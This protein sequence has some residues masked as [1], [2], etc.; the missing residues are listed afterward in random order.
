MSILTKIKRFVQKNAKI[1][2]ATTAVAVAAGAGFAALG[3][4][5]ADP[6]STRNCDGN[7]MVY[8]GAESVSE[9][10]TKYNKGDSHNKVYTTQDMYHAGFGISPSDINAMSSDTTVGYVTKSGDVYSGNTLVATNALTGGRENIAGSTPEKYGATA[11]FVRKP[12]VSFLDDQLK[13]FVVMK[14]GVF[15]YAILYSCGN[16]VKATPVPPK[17]KPALTCVELDATLAETELS[18]GDQTYNF[19]GKGSVKNNAKV[20][21]QAMTSTS[22]TV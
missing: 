20:L 15:Q 2:G 6:V 13:A 3:N 22:V 8:C 14:N 17:P 19:V 10:Q 12:S 18:S 11:F 5:H 4:V 21:S 16:A 7:A 9:L 1:V